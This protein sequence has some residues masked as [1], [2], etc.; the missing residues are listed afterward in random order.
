MIETL[1]DKKEIYETIKLNI[2]DILEKEKENQKIL[3]QKAGLNPVDWDFN[4][5]VDKI[6]VNCVLEGKEL[7]EETIAILEGLP[8]VN[9]TFISEEINGNKNEFY[10]KLQGTFLI[11]SYGYNNLKNKEDANEK[12][13]RVGRIV[14]NVIMSAD[15]ARLNTNGVI[16]KRFFSKREKIFKNVSNLGVIASCRFTLKVDYEENNLESSPLTLEIIEGECLIENDKKTE[17]TK[18][19][20]ISI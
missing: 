2:A 5:Y 14:R 11:D 13:E 16:T 20:H 19:V 9:I 4:I 15:Y 10:Q 12:S 8:V 7:E 17:N 1:I 18:K 6:D 3:A